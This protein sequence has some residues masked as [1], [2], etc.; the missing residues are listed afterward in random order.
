[1]AY[2]TKVEMMWAEPGMMPMKKPRAVPRRIGFT[3][4]RSSSVVG[5][6][7]RSFGFKTSRCLGDPA[8]TR[9]SE[10][11]KSPT[12]TGTTP[13]P[14]PR[15]TSPYE[16]RKYPDIWSMPIIPDIR[17]STTIARFFTTEPPVM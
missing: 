8:V 14:S 7:S 5:R 1:M 10:M 13:I 11:P 6:R 3:E 4:S 12:A 17:P 9:I 2:E 15:A 16:K